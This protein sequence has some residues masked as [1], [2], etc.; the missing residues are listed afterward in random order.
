MELFT[1]SKKALL[2][3]LRWGSKQQFW[4]AELKEKNLWEIRADTPQGKKLGF[5]GVYV[6]D[7]IVTSTEPIAEGFLRKLN[8]TWECSTPQWVGDHPGEKMRFCGYEI[9]RLQGGGFSLSQASY[10][11]DLLERYGTS[12][13]EK[14][15]AP[16]INMEQDEEYDQAMLKRAQMV[17][18]K[19][20][21]V[22]SRTRPDLGYIVNGMSRWTHRCPWGPCSSFP[23][24]LQGL[25]TVVSAITT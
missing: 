24:L 2:T 3:K 21:W 10:I 1:V 4:L 11:Q 15:A 7:I 20:Q 9:G 23:E 22:Q 18:A 25:G 19:L 5:V 14:V 17:T 8:E 6:D 12:G 16:K 13:Y